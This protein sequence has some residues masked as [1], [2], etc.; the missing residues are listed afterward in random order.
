MLNMTD[1]FILAG[2]RTPIGKFLGSFKGLTATDL[3]SIAIRAALLRAGLHLHDVDEV[4]MGMILSAGAG[5]A[6]AR[7]AALK[8]GLPPTVAALTINKVCGSGLKAVMLASQAVRLGDARIIVA[9]GMEN[10][11]QAPYLLR[12]AREGVKL[13][14]AALEDSMLLDGLWC[15][16][17]NCH[18]GE[19]AEF[20]ARSCDITRG[21]QDHFAAESQRR[22]AEAVAAGAFRD[23]IVPVPISIRGKE[24]VVAADEGPRPE[25]TL[26]GLGKLKPAFQVDG[27]VTAGNS[28]MLSDGAAAVIVA[29]EQTADRS[30]APWKARIL[31]SHTSGIEPKRI[32]LA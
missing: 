5:Q 8:A 4:I 7:Q 13:G 2:A 28:S 1:A 31:A 18:M 12:G 11:S 30:R 19:H 16:F 24:T 29:D 15:A 14:N 25:T 23:E 20:T 17:E 10:M 9:G 22:A 26:D 6:P 27:S 32:F 3:G 21:D